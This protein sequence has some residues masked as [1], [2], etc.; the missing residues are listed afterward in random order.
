MICNSIDRDC[1][2]ESAAELSQ[3]DLHDDRRLHVG[4]LCGESVFSHCP[5]HCVKASVV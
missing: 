3:V 2:P 5:N 1:Q 4:R